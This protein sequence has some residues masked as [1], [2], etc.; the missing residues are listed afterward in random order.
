MGMAIAVPLRR[1]G[2]AGSCA[3]RRARRGRPAAEHP[4]RAGCTRAPVPIRSLARVGRRD[5]ALAHGR[6]LQPGSR[7]YDRDFKRDAYL[8]LGVQ[9]VWLVDCEDRSVEVCRARGSGE[10]ARDTIRWAVP[11]A[12]VIVSVDLGEIF[13]GVD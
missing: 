2:D 8:A 12:N 10:I 3:R 1:A 11:N 7:I 13:A 9:Q 4:A 6:G 5:G